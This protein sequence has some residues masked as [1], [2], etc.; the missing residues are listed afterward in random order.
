M[1]VQTE[2]SI[3]RVVSDSDFLPLGLRPAFVSSSCNL[4]FLLSLPFVHKP[5]D[6]PN[7][8]FIPKARLRSFRSSQPST[9]FFNALCLYFCLAS[10]LP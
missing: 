9:S 1:A 6:P 3:I 7:I 2:K 4:S 10:L 8:P 5:V